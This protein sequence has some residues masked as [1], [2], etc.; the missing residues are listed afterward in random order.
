VAYAPTSTTFGR[1]NAQGNY[2]RT[3]QVAVR[4]SF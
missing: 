3:Y 1:V 4:Y 2:P